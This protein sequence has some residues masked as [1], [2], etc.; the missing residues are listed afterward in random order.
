MLEDIWILAQT[1]D[2]VVEKSTFGLIGEA[3]R[4][5]AEAKK[6]SQLTV[7]V[8]GVEEEA[9]LAVLGS[10]GADKVLSVRYEERP[11]C[12]SELHAEILFDLCQKHHPSCI[13]LCQTPENLD[14]GPRLAALLKTSFISGAVDL[15]IDGQGIAYAVRMIANGYLSEELRFHCSPLP[16]IS[17]QPSVLTPLEQVVDAGCQ[18]SS[19]L[20]RIEPARLKTKSVQIITASAENLNLEEADV[21][22][23]GGRGVGKGEE[24]AIIHELAEAIGGSVGGSRPMIDMG[25]LPFERQI[26]QTGKT[27]APRLLIAC[28]VSGANELTVGFED[29]GVVVAINTDQRARIFRFADLSIVGDVQQVLPLLLSRLQNQKEIE[30]LPC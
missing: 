28:G 5:L 4:L 18:I 25:I 6:D 14:L 19:V 15:R 9:E 20:S 30:T 1:R 29:A 16:V 24:F 22:V 8:L 7:V 3:R 23:V 12:E 13:L 2:G 11:C 26:G 21:I 27:V 17:F 10:Y